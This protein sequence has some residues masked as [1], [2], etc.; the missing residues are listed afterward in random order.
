ME[1]RG[2]PQ[3]KNELTIKSEETRIFLGLFS[4]GLAFM[5][6]F[7]HYFNGNFFNIINSYIGNTSYIL[8]LFLLSLAVRLFGYTNFISRIKSIVSMFLIWIISLPF[9]Q[10]FIQNTEYGINQSISKGTGGG[11]LGVFIYEFM[12]EWF[13]KEGSIIII[14]ILLISMFSIYS[15]ISVKN[16]IEFVKKLFPS[17][18][19]LNEIKETA[20]NKISENKLI[21][22]EP[23]KE[24]N[25]NNEN[26]EEIIDE[27]LNTANDN[28]TSQSSNKPN[29]DISEEQILLYPEW[30][31]PPI[32][33]LDV[34]PKEIDNSARHE[35]KAKIIEDT[36]RS[37][38]IGAQVVDISFGP[39]VIQYALKISVGT[40][41]NKISNLNKD[42]A[43]ALAAPSGSVRIQTPIPGT[44]LVGIEVPHEKPM[45]V[46]LR[47]LMSVEEMKERKFS[48]PL[49]FGKSVIG[50]NLV[51]DLAKMPHMLI[52]GATGSG[53]SVTVNAFIMGLIMTLTPDELR[54]IL[55]DPKTV[56][57]A[58][59]ADIPHLMVPVVTEMDKVLSVLTWG[60]EEMQSRYKKLKDK[61]VRNI[62]EYNKAMNYM[63]M[64]Y[65]VII[66]DEMA[67]LMLT[68]GAEVENKIVRLAQMARAVGIHL[69]LATQ[70]P[71]V[72]VI[73]GLI[74]AN[75]P[76]RI[77]MT[78]A[79]SIDS[80]V[81]LDMIGAED[82]LGNGD[83]LFK[84][85]DTSQPIRIQGA[86]C[87][88]QEIERVVN[89]LKKHG[90]PMYDEDILNTRT[91]NGLVRNDEFTSEDALSDP[92][93]VEAI[94]VI[95]SAQKGSASH[96]QRKL[97]IGY[98]RAARYIDQMEQ[99]GIV[100]APEGSKPRE[101]LIDNA[102]IF[103]DNLR[104]G[105]NKSV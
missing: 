41:V 16:I 59:Y 71:S 88:N 60:I 19:Q 44:S 14:L 33:L 72:N 24:Y 97:R 74:K 28:N 80:R 65:I 84:S 8:A 4:L 25:V 47:E 15:G 45:L 5:F 29:E 58:P 62:K 102:D 73:T 104:N 55:V 3:K 103:I 40:K 86:Y 57:F 76:A 21:K 6:L 77:A 63:A 90:E 51:K 98:N 50:E 37:F 18:E 56:E 43:L 105:P 64:P 95:V 13:D 87:S 38:N 2:R 1:R 54:L 20:R 26:E 36:L 11:K 82:L 9:F 35:E 101:V 92:V 75:I 100:S 68:T 96:I 89:F 46:S 93:F 34:P 99:L 91:S 10:I 53:K 23:I 32:S 7:S 27:K 83:M 17:T 49:L 22:N 85:P 69:V 78:V 30:E 67:D 12:D 81:I 79:T 66:I 31:Y 61:G 70:R 52:A 42:I 48:L 39:T 94:R